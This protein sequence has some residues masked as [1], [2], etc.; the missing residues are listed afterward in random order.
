MTG[1]DRAGEPA[2]RLARRLGL[3]DAVVV[4]L[5]AMLGT[6]VFVVWSPA[7][8]D[9]GAWLL[10]SL[11]LAAVVAFC[12][13]T[14]TAALAAVHP[15]SGGAYVYGRERLGRPWGVLA[16]LAF[17]VGKTTSCAAAALAVGAY[18]WPDHARPVAVVAVLA[19]T[20]ANLAGV[21]RT[22]A[23]TRVLLVVLGLVLVLVVVVGLTSSEH[24]TPLPDGSPLG[25]L[26]AAGLLFFAFAGYAR[27]ATLGEEVEDPARTIPRAVRISL[28][29]VFA[30]YLLVALAVLH[31]LGG[32]AAATVTPL[33]AVVQDAHA[34]GV[35]RVGGAVAALGALLSLQAGV[36]RTVF[37]M[38]AGGDAP[39]ALS[40]V[41]PRTR[42]PHR[43]E[44][45]VAAVAVV[46]V[47]LGGLVG[48]VTVSAAS[49]LV[50]YA[51]AN[52][53][54]LRLGPGESRL[55]R[56]VPLVGLAGCVVLAVA[57]AIGA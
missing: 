14:S 34:A 24:R 28:V 57:L 18:A 2:S 4:G 20:A 29:S 25:V 21:T 47:L 31:S 15:E 37:A 51:V 36:G 8:D 19:V 26:S 55:S 53:A 3:G 46:V 12:N 16:G 5:G 48:T 38:A 49:T 9:A 7:V 44:L 11:G 6:G 52:S 43:A 30:V 33:A 1:A 56:P 32:A 41:S 50:Y 17:T 10:L 39:R 45:L 35:V 54:A 40:A 13:A 22:V 42:V 23:V 27:V